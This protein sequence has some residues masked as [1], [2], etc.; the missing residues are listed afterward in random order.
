MGGNVCV[1]VL[2]HDSLGCRDVGLR[3]LPSMSCSMLS[4]EEMVA[5][6]SKGVPRA[7]ASV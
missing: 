4:S 6:I 2:S 3:A 7:L 5:D 1:D